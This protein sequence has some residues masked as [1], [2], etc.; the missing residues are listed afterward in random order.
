MKAILSNLCDSSH[1]SDFNSSRQF[2]VIER[3]AHD[4]Y[5]NIF[6]VLLHI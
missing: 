5:T 2:V 4:V 3:L 6:V 1:I